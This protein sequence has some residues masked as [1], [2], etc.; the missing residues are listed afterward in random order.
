LSLSR[1][2]GALMRI[3]TDCGKGLGRSPA[4]AD[5]CS[6]IGCSVIKPILPLAVFADPLACKLV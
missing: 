2:G 6:I 1:H 5:K 3:K 4:F